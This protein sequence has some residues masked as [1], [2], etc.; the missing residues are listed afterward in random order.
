MGIQA[1]R[2]PTDSFIGTF[3]R[4]SVIFLS[5][6]NARLI[7]HRG[8]HAPLCFYIN[9]TRIKKREWHD[10]LQTFFNGKGYAT[11]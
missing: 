7:G 10:K 5:F 3:S 8:A 11:I 4:D 9:R 1:P 2:Y 6:S